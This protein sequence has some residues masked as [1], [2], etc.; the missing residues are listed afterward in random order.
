MPDI[1]TYIDYR[2]YLRDLFEEQKT[3]SPYF[4]FRS[5]SQK[6]GIKSS[7]FISMVLQGKRSISDNLAIR[8]AKALQLTK[9]EIEYFRTMV[10]FSQAEIHE[11]RALHLEKLITLQ[12]NP[13]R[14]LTQDQYE[15]Y[16]RWYYSA[17]RELVAIT[18]ISDDYERIAKL[19]RP[20]IK[21][22]EAQQALE[23]LSRLGLVD[24]DAAGVYKRTDSVITSG[25]SQIQS[26]AIQQ[27][28][29]SSLE[30]AKTAMDRFSK[31]ERE[32][33]TITMSIDEQSY[34]LIRDKLARLR[35]E[36]MEIARS[37]A[38]PR[39]VYQLNMQIF[40]LSNDTKDEGYAQER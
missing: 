25:I 21:P 20:A 16:E 28:Q 22:Q 12:K 6:V 36:I 30:L 35:Q 10:Q 40:P 4:S 24:K 1:F 3:K 32:L 17:I 8:L 33:S 7:G 11:Q 14:K 26:C 27:F 15:F 38:N 29:R 18:P 2:T 9:K 31:N 19:V 37:V 39:R 23:V 13:I 5:L 34:E